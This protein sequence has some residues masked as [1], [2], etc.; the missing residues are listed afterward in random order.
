MYTYLFSLSF[1]LWPWSLMGDSQ[2]TGETSTWGSQNNS[3]D[4][5]Y[6]HVPIG[7]SDT[8]Y[9]HQSGNYHLNYARNVNCPAGY[10]E[11][12]RRPLSCKIESVVPSTVLSSLW[13]SSQCSKL[14]R[15]NLIMLRMFAFR[16][17]FADPRPCLQHGGL[18]LCQWNLTPSIWRRRE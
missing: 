8:F 1:V 6:E 5:G 2:S 3:Q 11:P 18:G 14:A 9:P 15:E 17:F 12:E 13:I 16:V 10:Q 7:M 4:D